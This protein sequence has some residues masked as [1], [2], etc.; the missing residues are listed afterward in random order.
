MGEYQA[1]ESRQEGFN[2]KPKDPFNW[3][4]R[5]E[6]KCKP[7]PVRWGVGIGFQ[8]FLPPR[9]SKGSDYLV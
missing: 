8:G 7:K 4:R 9:G 3:E 2:D 6:V 1:I 5:E